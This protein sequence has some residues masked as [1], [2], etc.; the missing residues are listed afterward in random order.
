MSHEI[1][2]SLQDLQVLQGGDS[3]H[4][5]HQALPLDGDLTYQH[6]KDLQTW[7]ALQGVSCAGGREC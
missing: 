7:H 6:G 3:W 4:E 5:G 2:K 1:Y